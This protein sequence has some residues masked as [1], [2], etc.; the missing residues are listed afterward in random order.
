M[1]GRLAVIPRRVR[2]SG[3]RERGMRMVG[4]N[5]K[6]QRLGEGGGGSGADA[7]RLANGC[8]D[9]ADGHLLNSLGQG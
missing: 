3:R 5:G 7:A 4:D 1:G 8:D 2:K 9:G 6:G